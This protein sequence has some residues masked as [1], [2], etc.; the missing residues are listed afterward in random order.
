MNFHRSNHRF[1]F[2]YVCVPVVG[3][4]NEQPDNWSSMS[5]L[6]DLHCDAPCTEGRA[7]GVGRDWLLNVVWAQGLITDTIHNEEYEYKGLLTSD[8]SIDDRTLCWLC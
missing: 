5:C 4:E 1:P 2:A 3:S 7:P 6:G 8:C